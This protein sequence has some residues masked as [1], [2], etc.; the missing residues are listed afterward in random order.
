MKPKQAVKLA[1]KALGCSTE[2]F[3]LAVLASL[4][5]KKNVRLTIDFA[6]GKVKTIRRYSSHDGSF[7]LSYKAGKE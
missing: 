2:S 6:D 1:E 4:R 3:F 5:S 7:E